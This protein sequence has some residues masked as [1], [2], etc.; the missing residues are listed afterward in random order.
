MEERTSLV[1]KKEVADTFAD[2]R[3]VVCDA[4]ILVVGSKLCGGGRRVATGN[5]QGVAK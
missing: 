4:D 5:L 2:G 1:V 3:F